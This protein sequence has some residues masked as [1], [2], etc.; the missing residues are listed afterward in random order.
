[1]AAYSSTLLSL[2]I[3]GVVSLV[4]KAL[5]LAVAFKGWF[6]SLEPVDMLGVVAGKR[7]VELLSVCFFFIRRS[8]CFWPGPMVYMD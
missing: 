1:M 7:S 8:D 4:W 6:T 3:S 2:S 5:T